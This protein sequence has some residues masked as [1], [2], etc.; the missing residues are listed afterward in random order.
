MNYRRG[1]TILMCFSNL[2]DKFT[3]SIN[4]SIKWEDWTRWLLEFCPSLQL[5]NLVTFFF[6]SI[7][8][9]LKLPYH[10]KVLNYQM[11]RKRPVLYF[12]TENRFSTVQFKIKFVINFTLGEHSIYLE[13]WG[14]GLDNIFIT[15]EE[16]GVNKSYNALIFCLFK[17][18][19][20]NRKETELIFFPTHSPFS[21]V[22]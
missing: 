21:T 1:S 6:T 17:C 11:N 13:F 19:C 22:I 9:N 12:K 3:L 7:F 20:W 10:W 14:Y 18:Q 4:L 2:C 5:L 15:K 16:I 8:E